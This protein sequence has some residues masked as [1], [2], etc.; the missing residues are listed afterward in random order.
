VIIP[1]GAAEPAVAEFGRK[2]WGLW[3]LSVHGYP[4]PQ[5]FAI[6]ATDSSSFDSIRH[7]IRILGEPTDELKLIVRSS[8]LSEDMDRRSA[9]GEF[10]TVGDISTV[11]DLRIA[12][13]SV[14]F[15]SRGSGAAIIQRQV[16]ARNAGV[17][18]TSHP[19]TGE[20]LVSVVEHVAGPG[21]GAVGATVPITTTEVRVD[22][23]GNIVRGLSPSSPGTIAQLVRSGKAIEQSRQSPSDIE[24]VI[25]DGNQLWLTQLRP[26]TTLTLGA[27]EFAA[28]EAGDPSV[29]IDEP[30][31]RL[32]TIAA[33]HGVSI[34]R[35]WTIKANTSLPFRLDAVPFSSTLQYSVVIIEPKTFRGEVRRRFTSGD[36]VVATFDDLRTELQPEFW[37]VSAIVKEIR[38]AAWTG[39]ATRDAEG[40]WVEAAAG[41]FVP[42]GVVPVQTARVSREYTLRSVERREQERIFRPSEDGASISATVDPVVV[43][44]PSV[45]RTL[46]PIFDEIQGAIEFG[47][48]ADG[49]VF[50]L[51]YVETDSEPDIHY[52]VSGVVSPGMTEGRLL[53]VDDAIEEELSV[54]WHARNDVASGSSSGYEPVIIAARRPFL[55]LMRFIDGSDKR[56]VGFVFEE[57]SILSH[58]SIQLRER[59]IP[60]VA[61]SSATIAAMQGHRVRLDASSGASSPTSRLSLVNSTLSD[62]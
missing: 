35:A 22:D 58:L 19:L 62:W 21:S 42:K 3:W 8:A 55:S 16:R 29:R 59:G 24:W 10:T 34:S 49:E 14:R 56:G 51:D 12:L 43:E 4:V 33:R 2:A 26:I 7:A 46:D 6:S 15:G 60:A 11:D 18:F 45:A 1:I 25:D 32:R 39:I 37:R 13:D 36:A 48:A 23:A 50:L 31:I 20:K 9:A 30:K 28:V 44:F 53:R 17:L 47:I 40:Y 61:S 52:G 5:G 27:A 38:A 57:P 54:N 41:H